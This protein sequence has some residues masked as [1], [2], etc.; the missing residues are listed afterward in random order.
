MASFKQRQIVEVN[1]KLPGN[2]FKKH[3]V[4]ILSNNN[5]IKLE[6]ILM[7]IQFENEEKGKDDN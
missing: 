4:V 5:A 7:R 1:F 6:G 2:V 3:P